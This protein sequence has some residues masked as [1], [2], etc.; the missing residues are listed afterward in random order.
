MDD[1]KLVKKIGSDQEKI[2]D[3]LRLNGINESIIKTY[4]EMSEI[5]RQMD[6]MNRSEINILNSTVKTLEHLLEMERRKNFISRFVKW[7]RGE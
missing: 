2:D 1:I 4:R 7:L 3:L 5:H 6:L